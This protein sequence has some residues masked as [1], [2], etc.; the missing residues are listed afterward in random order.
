MIAIKHLGLQE[1]TPVWEQMKQFTLSRA[2][3]SSTVSQDELWMVQHYPVYTQGQA[4]KPEHLLFP[5]EIPVVQTD[6]GGQITYHGPGQTVA[7]VLVNLKQYHLNVRDL[8]CLQE[9]AVITLLKK[10][11]MEANGSREAPGIY[12]LGK[13]IASIGLRIK[14]GFSYHGVALNVDMD[15]APFERIR[16]CGLDNMQM[17]QMKSYTSSIDFQ[18]VE[19]ELAEI[20]IDLLNA[21]RKS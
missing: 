4:G 17:T 9:R 2:S 15:L 3:Q 8:V 5:S 18:T 13:K 6:R 11:G 20:L 16:P 7:Y 10:Y 12:V 1:Y 14:Q 21:S 19:N